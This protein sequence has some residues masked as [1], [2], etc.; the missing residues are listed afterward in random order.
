MSTAK[1]LLL[2]FGLLAVGAVL[3]G[4]GCAALLWHSFNS[5]KFK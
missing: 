2:I 1:W 5:V 4:A 3:A